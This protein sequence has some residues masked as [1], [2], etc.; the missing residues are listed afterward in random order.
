MGRPDGKGY[1]YL[2]GAR[3]RGVNFDVGHGGGGFAFLT[4]TPAV[5][6]GFFTDT[7]STNLPGGGMTAAMM[8]LVTVMSKFLGLGM[9]YSAVVEAS[10]WAPSLRIGRPELGHLGAGAAADIA[11]LR[12]GSGSFRFQDA[13][14]GTVRGR[15][16]ISAKLMLKDGEVAWDGDSRVGTDR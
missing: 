12:L 13:H 8:D 4:A 7:I 2:R 1:E 9:P 11:V 3:V 15:Q 10:T 16:R 6:K 5:A 14:G